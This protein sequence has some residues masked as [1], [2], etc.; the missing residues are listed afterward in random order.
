MLTVIAID[1][2]TNNLTRFIILKLT[3]VCGRE[4]CFSWCVIAYTFLDRRRKNCELYPLVEKN[5]VPKKKFGS[6]KRNDSVVGNYVGRYDGMN[7]ESIGVGII[8][9][10]KRI[11]ICDKK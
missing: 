9:S 1:A 5:L 6:R 7:D 4:K 3:F 8:I 11:Q 10:Q 2:S